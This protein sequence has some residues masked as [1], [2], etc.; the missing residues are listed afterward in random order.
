M[1]DDMIQEDDNVGVGVNHA[2]INLSNRK[3]K[4]IFYFCTFKIQEYFIKIID[5]KN[6]RQIKRV[7]NHK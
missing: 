7:I 5:F 3:I 1:L 4:A 2:I 6:N